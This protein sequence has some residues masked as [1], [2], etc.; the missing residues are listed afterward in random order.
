LTHGSPDTPTNKRT[1]TI[2]G[3]ALNPTWDETLVFEHTTTPSLL[4]L[5][6]LHIEIKS[7]GLSAQWT[8]PVESAPR[9]YH[10][11][12]LY[13]PLFSRYVFATLFVRIDVDALHEVRTA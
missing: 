1:A 4:A 11:L 7:K 6:F 10:H 5:T 8:K 12:P 2:R 3:K 13:D 9:G